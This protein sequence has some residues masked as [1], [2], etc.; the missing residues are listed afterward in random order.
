MH[1]DYEDDYY[2][3]AEEGRQGW[4]GRFTE[5]MSTWLGAI[6]ALVVIGSLVL[7]GYRLGQ[8]DATAVPVIRASLEPTKV[9]PD[10]PGGAEVPHQDIT[11]YTAGDGG[12]A[13]P[14]ITFAAPPERPA[15]EDVP[16]GALQEPATDAGEPIGEA[17]V[18]YGLNR[19]ETR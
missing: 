15:E 10:D 1:D 19:P 7:W 14:Q 3:T 2:V 16:M 11:S 5:R 12:A 17:N 9:Q 13:P 4:R 8:R 18:I 6:L